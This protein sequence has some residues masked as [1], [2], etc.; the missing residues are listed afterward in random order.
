MEIIDGIHI[1]LNDADMKALQDGRALMMSGTIRDV[2]VVFYLI[3]ER[4][5][6]AM[7]DKAGK[8]KDD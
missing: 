8:A 7:K 5:T 2:D 3:K 6:A 4:E 1:S